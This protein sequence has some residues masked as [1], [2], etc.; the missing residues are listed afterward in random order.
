MSAMLHSD[1][2]PEF[3][4][5]GELIDLP[6]QSTQTLTVKRCGKCETELSWVADDGRWVKVVYPG[7]KNWRT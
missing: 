3:G 2:F 6:E 1:L 7:M 5:E 4:C